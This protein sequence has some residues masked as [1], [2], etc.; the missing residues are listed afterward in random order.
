MGAWHFSSPADSPCTLKGS[1]LPRCVDASPLQC[2]AFSFGALWENLWESNKKERRGRRLWN[3]HASRLWQLGTL[4]KAEGYVKSLVGM[5]EMNSRCVC[6][7]GTVRQTHPPP[8]TAAA[9]TT[10]PCFRPL[11]TPHPLKTHLLFFPS[12]QPYLP[13]PNTFLP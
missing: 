6:D 8:T 13:L 1:Y 5:L 9:A 12:G 3:T 2:V 10:R 4:Y 11:S 7:F